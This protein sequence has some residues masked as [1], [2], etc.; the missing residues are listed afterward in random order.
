[1]ATAHPSA[2]YLISATL[3][4]NLFAMWSDNDMRAKVPKYRVRAMVKDSAAATAK[5]P[6]LKAALE[7]AG[8]KVVRVKFDGEDSVR[9]V[10]ELPQEKVDELTK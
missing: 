1:M 2:R 3:G 4:D 8:H 9:V 7:R 10:L 5:V 6:V